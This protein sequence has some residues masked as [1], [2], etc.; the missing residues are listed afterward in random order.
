MPIWA[1][2]ERGGGVSVPTFGAH[3]GPW[4]SYAATLIGQG[5]TSASDQRRVEPIGVVV[6]GAA[7]PALRARVSA[8]TTDQSDHGQADHAVA[9]ELDEVPAADRTPSRYTDATRSIIR[10]FYWPAGRVNPVSATN[11]AA[12]ARGPTKPSAKPSSSMRA[13]ISAR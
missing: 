4:H 11:A 12:G 3:P 2:V 1:A 13:T 7:G 5:G 6:E 8:G 9:V 10:S